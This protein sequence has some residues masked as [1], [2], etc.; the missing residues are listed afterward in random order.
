MRRQDGMFGMVRTTSS[1]TVFL[2]RFRDHVHG[3]V[4]Q[5]RARAAEAFPYM[6]Q[7]CKTSWDASPLCLMSSS[8]RPLLF[9]IV[10]S[11]RAQK[12]SFDEFLLEL[13]RAVEGFNSTSPCIRAT[14]LERQDQQDWTTPYWQRIDGVLLS[15]S[16]A[17]PIGGG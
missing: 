13:E 2:V 1:T 16:I 3:N 12:M 17:A 14:I 5:V 9:C 10:E 4:I 8:Q 11:T 7:L 15:P 6:L